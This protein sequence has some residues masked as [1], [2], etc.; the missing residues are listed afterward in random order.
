[1]TFGYGSSPNKPWNPNQVFDI[2]DF[3]KQL[4]NELWLHY[5]TYGEVRAFYTTRLMSKERT[6]FVAHSMGGLVVKK[7]FEFHL[8]Q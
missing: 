1:M 7:V 6:V 2:S 3:A 8:I 5:T 4:A